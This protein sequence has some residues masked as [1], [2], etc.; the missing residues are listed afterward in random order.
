MIP[1]FILQNTGLKINRELNCILF[2]MNRSPSL[3]EAH[4]SPE[5]GWL[6]YLGFLAA[7]LFNAGSKFVCHDDLQVPAK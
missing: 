6:V 3:I 1:I 7:H 4:D 5:K 2:S